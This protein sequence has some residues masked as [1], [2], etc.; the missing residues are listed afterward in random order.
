MIQDFWTPNLVRWQSFPPNLRCEGGDSGSENPPPDPKPAPTPPTPAASEPKF[1]QEDV[2]RLITDRLAREQR[3]REAESKKAAEDAELKRLADQQEFKQIADK[4][5]SR[6]KE[7]EPTVQSL[8]AER[9]AYQAHILAD[10]DAAMKE[11]PE[12]FKELVPT[13]GDAL[14]RLRA[15][16]AA[17][18]AYG[19]ISGTTRAPV[20]GNTTKPKPNESPDATTDAEYKRLA[21]SGRYRH[22]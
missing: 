10:I 12:E 13:E 20:P 17:S 15:F 4:H 2:N 6:V 16:Q 9:D 22:F 1:T 3:V 21:S 18:K 11:W 5:E 8:T 19:K 14:N 7:L